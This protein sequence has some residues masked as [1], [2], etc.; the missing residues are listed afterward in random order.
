MSKFYAVK[1]C[2]NSWRAASSCASLYP[3]FMAMASQDNRG[4]ARMRLS[5]TPRRRPLCRWLRFA[6]KKMMPDPIDEPF[7][8]VVYSISN[9]RWLADQMDQAS[10]RQKVCMG[11]VRDH[12]AERKIL[13]Q[14]NRPQWSACW[15][16]F[17]PPTI[18][19]DTW[20]D[21]CA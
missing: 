2:G 17:L 5:C 16:A 9:C 21:G 12:A 18:T 15:R 6:Q 11:P 13:R 19:R 4:K 3:N 1:G 8:V 7:E 10:K 20:H 14:S